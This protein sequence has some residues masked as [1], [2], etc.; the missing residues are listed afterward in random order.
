[1]LNERDERILLLLKKFDFMTRDQLNECLRLGTVRHTNRILH[2]LSDY[3]MS[4]REGYQTIYYLSKQGRSYV[5]CEKVRKKGGHVQHIVMR[6]EMWLFSSQPKDWKNEVKVSD[7][8]STVITDAM[9]S[10]SWDRKHFL[11]VDSTQTMKENR[12]KIKRYVELLNNGLV[13]E[14]LGH[15]PTLVWLTTTEHR[16]DQLKKECTGLQAVMVFTMNDIK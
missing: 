6:N 12:N 11:E 2:N 8:H 7:G 3:L 13:E 16:R 5:D 14:K 4:I 1:M 10:D 15:F 9:F